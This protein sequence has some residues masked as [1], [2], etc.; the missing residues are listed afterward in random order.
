MRPTFNKDLPFTK[1]SWVGNPLDD[2]GRYRNL[3]DKSEKGFKDLFSWQLKGNEFK[4][5]K[6]KQ[7]TNVDVLPFDPAIHGSENFVTWLGH[8]SMYLRIN[9]TNIIIDPVLFNVGP[10]KRF[11]ALPCKIEALGPIEVILLSHNHRDHLDERSI[12]YLCTANPNAI[13]YTGLGIGNQIRKWRLKN[14]IIEAGW[15]QPYPAF[16]NIEIEYL[17][18][19]HWN[20]RWLTDL[21]EMLWGS[22]MIKFDNYKFYFAGDSGFD[23]HFKEIGQTHKPDFACIGIGAYEPNWF[24]APAHTNPQEALKAAKDLGVS[25]WLPIH[26][27]TFDLSDEPIYMPKQTLIQNI[28]NENSVNTMIANV[29]ERI[30]LNPNYSIDICYQS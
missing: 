9:D 1:D 24:M 23:K 26:Y 19:K 20:R 22:F 13:I 16:K 25:S 21:N 8:A 15:Y 14:E 7:K 12:K 4:K 30:V 3:Y 2:K 29:G 28:K 18:A 6:I 27:G 17:P 10:L 5:L 11:T